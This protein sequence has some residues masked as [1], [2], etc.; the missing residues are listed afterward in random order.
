MLIK[1]L[2]N[3]NRSYFYQHTKLGNDPAKRLM[4]HNGVKDELGLSGT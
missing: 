4:M 3:V 1:V 2:T